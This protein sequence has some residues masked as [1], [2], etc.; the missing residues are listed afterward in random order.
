[1]KGGQECFL[2]CFLVLPLRQENLH[3]VCIRWEGMM[4]WETKI[5]DI[6]ERGKNGLREGP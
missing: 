4:Q 2:F 1:M 3:D 5:N 6:R